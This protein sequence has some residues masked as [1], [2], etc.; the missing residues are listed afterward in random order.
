M[1]AQEMYAKA[2][3]TMSVEE[4]KKAIEAW[5]RS[6]V[7]PI[8][9]GGDGIE[10]GGSLMR[11]RNKQPVSRPKKKEPVRTGAGEDYMRDPKVRAALATKP[12]PRE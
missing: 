7:T 3:E 6:Q 11:Q 9:E 12:R 10:A 5:I 8:G 2:R 1:G 4:A